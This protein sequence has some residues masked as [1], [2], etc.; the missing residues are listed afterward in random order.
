MINSTGDPNWYFT[1]WIYERTYSYVWKPN[2]QVIPSSGIQSGW[3]CPKC[4]RVYS[5]SNSECQT[6]N[7]AVE[8]AEYQREIN[9]MNESENT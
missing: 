6:C 5:P 2:P 7:D 1:P 4:G 9:E 8:R 3:I